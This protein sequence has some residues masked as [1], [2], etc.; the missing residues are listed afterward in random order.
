MGLLILLLVCISSFLPTTVSSTKPNFIIFQ[1]DDLPFYW[2]EA[3]PRS[4]TGKNTRSFATPNIDRIRSEGTTF[5]RAYTASPMCA[6]SRFGVLTGRYAARCAYGQTKTTGC[7]STATVTDVTVPNSKI[8][9]S[10]GTDLAFNVQSKL[11]DLGYLTGCAGKW[12]LAAEGRNPWADYPAVQATVR[13]AGFDYADGIYIGNM[14]D[15]DREADGFSHNMEWVTAAARTFFDQAQAASKPF[16]LYF[17]PTMPHSPD[18]KQAFFNFTTTSTP[19]GTLSAPPDAGMSPR[20]DLWAKAQQL[21]SRKPEQALSAV[22]I[23]DAMGSLLSKLTALNMLDSTLI[24]F[25]M[26]HGVAAKG[27]LYEGGIRIAMMARYPPLFAANS[28]VE[29]PVTNL[30]LAPS[31]LELASAT[32]SPPAAGAGYDGASFVAAASAAAAGTASTLSG[33]FAGN[34]TIVSELNKDRTVVSG[35]YKYVKLALEAGG[36]AGGNCAAGSATSGPDIS[37]MYPAASASEQLYD[38]A[39]DGAEQTN[40]ASDAA[41][42]ATL[43]SMRAILACHSSATAIGSTAPAYA[44]CVGHRPNRDLPK[45]AV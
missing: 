26:D 16:F 43:A 37:G 21:N 42:Q 7:L 6:P 15:D 40:L 28:A 34:R 13:A 35:Q 18:I 32:S 5:L 44:S 24:I 12:H 29:G 10:P 36:G 45:R 14:N 3:P 17:N 33:S 38:L 9:S 39:A 19:A 23:D 20:A 4:P 41:H 11:R 30:D 2:A 27:A 1:P 22:W 25:V 8:T 31:F